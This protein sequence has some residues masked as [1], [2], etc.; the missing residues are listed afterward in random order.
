MITVKP[1]PIRAPFLH[2][3]VRFAY[4]L[5]LCCLLPLIL[6]VF[7]KKL[8]H[9]ATQKQLSGRSFSERFGKVSEAIAPGGIHIH[10]VSVGEVNAASGLICSLLEEYPEHAITLT[11]SSTTG[12]VHAHS[13]FKDKVHHN[14]LPIDI[15]ACMTRFYNQ[16]KPSM[17]LVTEVEVWPNMLSICAKRNIPVILIN[18]R[19]TAK[20]LRNYRRLSLLFRHT[21]RQFTA[22]CVQSSDS[23][24][25][26]SAFGVYKSHLKLSRNMK[27]DLLPNQEDE[28]LGQRIIDDYRIA[29]KPILLAASTHDPE[30]KIALEAYTALKQRHPDLVLIVVPRHP[31]RFDEVHHIM[32]ATGY[33]VARISSLTTDPEATSIDAT[34]LVN[35]DCL[36][37]DTMGWL[38][39]CYSI[40]S[41]AFVGG[42]FANKGGHNALEAALYSKPIVMGP[43]IFNNP[44]ICQ[45]LVAQNAL[46]ICRSQNELLSTIE[47]WLQYPENA[48]QDGERGLKVLLQNAG[49]VEYTMSI[50][51]PIIDRQQ[52]NKAHCI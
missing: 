20:S 30:E 44:G 24:E 6:V 41:V 18:A 34:E 45:H 13:L 15:P 29:H 28:V 46:I 48:A 43:S 7:K 51:R 3:V 50:L 39:A 47:H 12:A 21:L 42:S 32:Q 11:T 1:R 5:A 8:Q 33:K 10:C 31:H 49:S 35:I 2:N 19:M 27:F 36:L 26:F 14:Y 52:A 38:K 16:V 25:N 37:I 9:T 17:V 40:C 23:F 4:T 22:I